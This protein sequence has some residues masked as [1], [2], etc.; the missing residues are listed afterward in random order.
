M[1]VSS[2]S[3]AEFAWVR[4]SLEP[5]L[6]PAMLRSLQARAGSA[7]GVY[8]L[9]DDSLAAIVG[10]GMGAPLRGP[11]SSETLAAIEATLAWAAHPDHYLLTLGDAAYPRLLLET[12]D[13]PPLLYAIGDL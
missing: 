4:L 9:S 10:S 5:D 12:P 13:P 1:P 2:P 6:K 11:P 7:E 8:A 3:N